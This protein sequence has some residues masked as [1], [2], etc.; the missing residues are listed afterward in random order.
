MDAHREQRGEQQR[1]VVEQQAGRADDHD[2]DLGGLHDPDDLRLVAASASWPASADSR[3][4]GRM[5]SP[6]AIALNVAS[7]SASR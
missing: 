1:D 2:Q 3:K 7:C 4:K 5:N 6:P